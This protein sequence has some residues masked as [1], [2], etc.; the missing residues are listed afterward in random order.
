MDALKD[1]PT[2]EKDAL[3]EQQKLIISK[4]VGGAPA[5]SKSTNN[6]STSKWKI[7]GYIIA[8]FLALL[9]PISQ[10]LL[11]KLPYVGNNYTTMLAA[12]T[13]IFSACVAIAIYYG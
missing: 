10:G 4:F 12:T 9:N 5:K 7:V 6:N 2:D 1:L 13:L 8:S 3:S 11:S